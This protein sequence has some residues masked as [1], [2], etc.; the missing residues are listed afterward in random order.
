M[1]R[2]PNCLRTLPGLPL[3]GRICRKR[4]VPALWRWLRRCSGWRGNI[5]RCFFQC[6]RWSE[7]IGRAGER[8]QAISKTSANAR[9]GA[10]SSTITRLLLFYIGTVIHAVGNLNINPVG[11]FCVLPWPW[12]WPWFW[13]FCRAV[14]RERGTILKGDG[15]PRGTLWQAP[16]PAV[17]S[18]PEPVE[19]S[20]LW[21]RLCQVRHWGKRWL[22][23]SGN[24]QKFG[25]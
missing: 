8:Q 24:P 5:E 3:H 23:R 11:R 17:A 13:R 4:C 22:R 18:G 20:E 10:G 15:V 12:L 25:A 14:R 16:G 9:I 2:C 7:G 6:K 19:P 21:R 1:T